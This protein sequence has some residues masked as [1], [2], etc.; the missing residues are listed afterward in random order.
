MHSFILF[1]LGCSEV[2]S[3]WL[4]TSELANQRTRR[5]LFT[6]VV[7]TNNS[8]NVLQSMYWFLAI[9]FYYHY[10]IIIIRNFLIKFFSHYL[11]LRTSLL[12]QPADFK[13]MLAN[14]INL[15]SFFHLNK[16]VELLNN[17]YILA[18][19]PSLAAFN[20]VTQFLVSARNWS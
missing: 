2:N 9:S 16:F 10:I 3:T 20:E 15:H 8:N 13:S 4:I 14:Y 6:W 17:I 11:L 1:F 12:R 5:V 18:Q 19:N 7:Y